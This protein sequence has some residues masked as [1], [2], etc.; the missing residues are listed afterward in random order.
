MELLAIDNDTHTIVRTVR[1]LLNQLRNRGLDQTTIDNLLHERSCGKISLD[2]NGV[3]SLSLNKKVYLNPVERSLYILFLKH[4]QGI[5]A[6]DIWQYYDELCEIYSHQTVYDEKDR[7]EAVVD[8]LC[9]DNKA[10]FHTNIS[11]I[12]RKISD[13]VGKI[14]AEKYAIVRDKTGVYRIAVS[15][16][17]VTLNL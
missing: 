1:T 5:S 8:A 15:R 13:T 7:I 12:K 4:D 16:N 17:L 2:Q 11:R 3:L 6:K 9:D 14:E 10:T